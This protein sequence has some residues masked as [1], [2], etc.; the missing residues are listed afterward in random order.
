MEGARRAVVQHQGYFIS[1]VHSRDRP[2]KI[3]QDMNSV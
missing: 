2:L 1:A 3:I